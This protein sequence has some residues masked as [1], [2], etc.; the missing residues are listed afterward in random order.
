MLG[1]C[2]DHVLDVI[3]GVL[4]VF[5]ARTIDVSMGTVRI[6][7]VVRG[8]RKVGS[9]IGF[10]E[11]MIWATAVSQVIPQLSIDRIHYLLAFAGGFA[12]GNF[13][14]SLIEEKIALGYALA[15]VV[16]KSRSIDLADEFRRAGFGV[17]TI[18]SVGIEGPKPLY[19]IAFR[20]KDMGQFL[21]IVKTYDKEAFCTITD[22][23]SQSGGFMRGAAKKK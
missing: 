15:Y 14:G 12:T 9:L 21:N 17:T 3:L 11:I 7:M 6:I 5:L 16:P 8:R 20:R 2:G 13:L 22:I 10:F 23:R 1:I 18:L 19:T 4:L